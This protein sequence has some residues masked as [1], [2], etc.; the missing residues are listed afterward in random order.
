MWWDA[1]QT[2]TWSYSWGLCSWTF[3]SR[4]L[5]VHKNVEFTVCQLFHVSINFFFFFLCCVDLHGQMLC[6]GEKVKERLSNSEDYQAFLKCIEQYCTDNITRPQLQVQV[7]VFIC[8]VILCPLIPIQFVFF[9]FIINYAAFVPDCIIGTV[10]IY[11]LKQ[12]W[13]QGRCSML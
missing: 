13:P 7:N 1:Y 3:S 9:I 2:N 4:F 10:L 6:L 12:V 11:I 5:S 8:S